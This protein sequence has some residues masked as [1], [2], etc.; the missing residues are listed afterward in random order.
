MRAK[1]ANLH[2]CPQKASIYSIIQATEWAYILKD[3]GLTKV[4]ENE[5][6]HFQLNMNILACAR[7]TKCCSIVVPCTTT[8]TRWRWLGL[9]RVPRSDL[10]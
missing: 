10:E 4:V 9:K 2:H 6:Y 8:S 1:L 3:L 5:I 7:K